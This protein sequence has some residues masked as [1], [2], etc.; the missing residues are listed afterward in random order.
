MSPS[1]SEVVE[2]PERPS[3]APRSRGPGA[4]TLV[5]L[6]AL[7]LVAAIGVALR[8]P[9][10]G[11]PPTGAAGS[12]VRIVSLAPAITE[13][14]IALQAGDLLVGVSEYCR[15]EDLGER[16]RVGTALTPQLEALVRLEPTLILTSRVA[17]EQTAPLS[18]IAPTRQLPWL[19]LEEVVPSVRELG[20]LV[21]R[22]E[23]AHALAGRL[24]ELLS[25]EP[26]PDAPRVLL[27]MSYEDT[28]DPRIWFLRKN[29][30]HGSVLRAAGGRNAMSQDV[31]GQPHLSVEEL[32]R[33][34]PDQIILLADA[35]KTS[36]E[37]ARA[38]LDELR[39]LTPL[40]AVRFERLGVV[41]LPNVFSGGP[42]ILD[43]VEPLR[44][45]IRR[46]HDGS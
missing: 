39:K 37:Q 14:L 30:L 28:G 6:A 32:L 10:A 25:A 19:T 35:D 9:R 12:S 26:P 8:W 5:L 40:G 34:D 42:R 20:E 36:E 27:T 45:E 4:G 11:A 46:L 18:R 15:T 43:L 7:A 41:R 23:A 29:S 38:R 33:L 22:P 24:Q 16:P 1:R 31:T 2:P 17:G 13:T 44:R 3:E 21:D